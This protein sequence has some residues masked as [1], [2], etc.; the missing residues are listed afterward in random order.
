MIFNSQV[1]A[2]TLPT[3][4]ERLEALLEVTRKSL[5]EAAELSNILGPEAGLY[6]A[7]TALVEAE[8]ALDMALMVRR[9]Y[10]ANE[11]R[12]HALRERI[13]NDKS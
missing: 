13:H 9:D 4:L 3:S 2:E 1:P 10:V 6:S 11:S 12:K 8:E 5:K 7:I